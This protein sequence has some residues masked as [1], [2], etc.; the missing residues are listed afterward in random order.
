MARRN[1][2]EEQEIH[3]KFCLENFIDRYHAEGQGGNGK[4]IFFYPE[5]G[6]STLH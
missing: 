1:T 2:R 3:V 4:L 5:D 6:G